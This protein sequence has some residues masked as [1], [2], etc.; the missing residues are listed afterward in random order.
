MSDLHVEEHEEVVL[1][2][3]RP[4]EGLSEGDRGVVV[5]V[6]RAG[7]GGYT[8]PDG[9]TVEFPPPPNGSRG[10][11]PIVSLPPEQVRPADTPAQRVSA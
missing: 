1:T 9:Y 2:E 11:R 7:E 5:M 10:V 8:G 6:H 4:E 3:D